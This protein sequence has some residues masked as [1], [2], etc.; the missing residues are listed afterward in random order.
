MSTLSTAARNAACDGVVDLVDAGAGAG[1]L[2]IR[3]SGTLLAEITLADPAFGAASAGVAT[4]A[5]FPRSD[6]SADA[7]GT[8]D[9]YQITDSDDNVII[10][11]TVG[12]GSGD[13]SLDNTDIAAGQTVTI[14]SLTHTQPAS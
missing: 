13:I 11:G 3:A 1:K 2:K 10:S 12:E 14:N 5:S 7:S 4:G 9:N 6:T 8:A